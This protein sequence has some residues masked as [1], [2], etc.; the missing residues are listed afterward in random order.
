MKE[1]VK[2]AVIAL[3]LAGLALS[4]ACAGSSGVATEQATVD[5]LPEA[6]QVVAATR[7]QPA[8]GN[9]EL[10]PSLLRNR[11]KL[12][13]CSDLRASHRLT[14]KEPNSGFDVLQ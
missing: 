12:E 11:L 8:A 9:G 4:A 5:P 7:V 3:V 1:S 13:R 10:F 2:Q 6:S 14:H